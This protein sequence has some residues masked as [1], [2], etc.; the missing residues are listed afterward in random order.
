MYGYLVHRS[1]DRANVAIIDENTVRLY[2]HY[3]R[4]SGG[5]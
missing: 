1:A 4:T 2:Y 5:P 3:I